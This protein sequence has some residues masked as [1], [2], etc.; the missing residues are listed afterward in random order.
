MIIAITLWGITIIGYIIYNLFTKNKKLENIVY[1]Q[2]YFIDG[3][4]D[5]MKEI[6]KAAEQIDSKIWVQ[7]DPEF[8]VLME[9]VKIMQESI[10]QFISDK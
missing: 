3:I 4:K 7:S 9:N 2:Q 6:N 5:S 1:K 8:L 10:N